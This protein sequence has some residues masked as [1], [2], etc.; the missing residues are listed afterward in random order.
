MTMNN[1]IFHPFPDGGVGIIMPTGELPLE[2]VCLK[3]VPADTPYLIGTLENLPSDRHFR[4]AWEADFIE[5]HG[6]G[7]GSDAWFA[8]DR[9]QNLL[10][11]ANSE[12]FNSEIQITSKK[13][14]INMPKAKEI[15]RNK[16]RKVRKSKLQELDVQFQREL[17]KGP[18]ANTQPIVDKKQELR[19]LPNHPD[20]EAATTVEELKATWNE[21]LLGTSPYTEVL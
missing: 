17:E 19:D 3:D 9:P 11:S 8:S 10:K 15:H 1:L 12:T 14:T 6:Y 4:G 18:K 5:P 16:I 7:I 2:E 20:I 13:I 21:E